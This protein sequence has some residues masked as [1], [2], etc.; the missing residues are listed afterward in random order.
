MHIKKLNKRVEIKN[1]LQIKLMLL[2]CIVYYWMLYLYDICDA[3]RS[4]FLTRIVNTGLHILMILP[5]FIVY[6]KFG[7][8]KEEPDF[9]NK[10]QYI[11][12]VLMTLPFFAA[13]QIVFGIEPTEGTKLLT[14]GIFW[15]LFY[16]FIIVGITEEFF[17][18]VYLLGEL[19]AILGKL[20]WLAPLLSGAFFGLTHLPNGGRESMIMNIMVGIALGY[21]KLYIKNCT[22]ISLVIAHGLY[23]FIIT[24]I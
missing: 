10:K 3:I 20:R 16:Y 2:L 18:R 6:R 12:A 15:K 22:F 5:A 11:W 7:L 24:M 21:G 8:H 19:E 17:F 4:L 14:D 1:E 9:K 13:C 23:D